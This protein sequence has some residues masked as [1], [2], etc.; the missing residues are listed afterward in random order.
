MIANLADIQI[1]P[2]ESRPHI[3]TF[4]FFVIDPNHPHS[5]YTVAR[6]TG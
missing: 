6:F 4:R 5:T 2:K 1:L 3:S